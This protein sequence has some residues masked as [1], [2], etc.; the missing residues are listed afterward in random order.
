[1]AI[2]DDLHDRLSAL[3]VRVSVL[4]SSLGH[5]TRASEKALQLQ[6]AD[7]AR[8]LD[9]L[10]HEA[11]RLQTMAQTYVPRDVWA[12]EHRA[13]ADVLEE[14]KAFQNRS[15]GVYSV[16]AL[17]ISAVVSVVVA[18]VVRHLSL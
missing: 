6:T 17:V 2:S 8:R 18:L 12:V 3:A 7:L 5:T 4:E 11:M 9:A 10:N 15:V 16:L 1:L 14:V 13:L